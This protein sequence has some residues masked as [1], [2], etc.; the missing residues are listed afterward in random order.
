[1]NRFMIN[2]IRRGLIQ[3]AAIWTASTD[4]DKLPAAI[5]VGR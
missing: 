4:L 5:A 2:W 1:M 3:L